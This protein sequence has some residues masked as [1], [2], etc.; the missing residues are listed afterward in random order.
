MQY[1]SNIL[2]SRAHAS[3]SQ[4]PSSMTCTCTAGGRSAG[5][6]K[7]SVLHCLWPGNL[8][9]AV[10]LSEPQSTRVLYSMPSLLLRTPRTSR[11]GAAYA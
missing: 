8:F 5:N 9:S 2:K 11:P 3:G 4:V 10:V 7:V 6:C 1:S